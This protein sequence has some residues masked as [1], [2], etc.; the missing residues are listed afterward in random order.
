MAVKTTFP[1]P[2]M[3]PPCGDQFTGSFLISF[4]TLLTLNISTM[5]IIKLRRQISVISSHYIVDISLA[6]LSSFSFHD[7]E[8]LDF[9]IPQELCSERN[10]PLKNYQILMNHNTE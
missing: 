1:E 9:P 4:K 3:R 6:L 5:K 8:L 10:N 2:S 7:P